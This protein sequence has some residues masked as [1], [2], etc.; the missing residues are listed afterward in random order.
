VD[1]TEHLDR[2]QHAVSADGEAES[3]SAS[4]ALPFPLGYKI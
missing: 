3:A 4:R 1:I 2:Y